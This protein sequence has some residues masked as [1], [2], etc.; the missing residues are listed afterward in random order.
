MAEMLYQGHGS[1]RIT[2]NAGT[3]IYVDPFAG[4]GYDAEADLV[5][6]THEHPDHDKVDLMPRAKGCT[7][8]RA[9]DFQP[10]PGNYKTLFIPEPRAEK[11]CGIRMSGVPACNKNHPID[12]CVGIIIEFDGI[13]FYASGDTS[14]TEWMR[15]GKLKDMLI[16]YAV[17]PGDG[18]YNM[19]I[20]EASECAKMI[21]ALYTIPVH[22]VPVHDPLDATIFSRERAEAFQ[23]EGRVILEP[24]ETLE[25]VEAGK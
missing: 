13:T 10:E 9:A 5:L 16:D 22:L 20:D 24:G 15:N 21:D 14:T 6:V 8:L 1:Y 17:L 12:E 25:L 3:V 18:F 11:P 4:R 23:A 19:D 7:I 2:T